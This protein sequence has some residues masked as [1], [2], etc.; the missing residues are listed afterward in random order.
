MTLEKFSNWWD[1][2]G[3]GELSTAAGSAPA[4]I[5][6]YTVSR[7]AGANPRGAVA[8]GGAIAGLDSLNRIMQ[9]RRNGSSG[10]ITPSSPG[11]DLLKALGTGALG[12]IAGIGIS[13]LADL[14]PPNP[15]ST[16]I[17]AGLAAASDFAR[18]RGRAAIERRA[19]DNEL[20]RQMEDYYSKEA[21]VTW[22]GHP[23]LRGSLLNTKTS[24]A[25]SNT[26]DALR[27]ESVERMADAAAAAPP[28][29]ATPAAPPSPSALQIAAA[30]AAGNAMA[31]GVAGTAA[32]I[33]AGAP[34]AA[35]AAPARQR[36]RPQSRPAASRPAPSAPS[37]PAAGSSASPSA[38]A[39]AAAGAAA[40]GAAG[41]AP[42]GGGF[43]GALQ[44]MIQTSQS[45][46]AGVADKP[47]FT[48]K[49]QAKPPMAGGGQDPKVTAYLTNKK[50][51]LMAGGGQDPKVTAYLTNKKK[52]LMAGVNQ[53]GNLKAKGTGPAPSLASLLTSPDGQ[54]RLPAGL[55][56][57]L[58][59]GA[60]MVSTGAGA[61][62]GAARNLMQSATNPLRNIP[63]FF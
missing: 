20:N 14:G 24:I 5:G 53:G 16:A 61:V 47:I 43:G 63:N 25:R 37:G 41:A 23:R 22:Y 55:T 30:R 7:F 39:G 26:E 4:A 50:K 62:G 31:S 38:I 36:P 1:T 28:P 60:N 42:A 6:G 18:R 2:P 3:L 10:L 40:A 46:P 45:M 12:G 13:T 54:I 35:P 27:P 34:A 52:D 32:G 57:S 8:V 33:A 29:A 9:A 15:R 49:P 56:G 17:F 44:R 51:D 59:S 48:D 11:Q 21:Q 58:T 19:Y